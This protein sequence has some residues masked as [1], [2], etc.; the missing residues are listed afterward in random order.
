MAK[1]LK[2]KRLWWIGGILVVATAV[3]FIVFSLRAQANT[4]TQVNEAEVVEAFIGDL[5]ASATASGRVLPRRSAALAPQTPGRVT[6]V[7][8]RPGD[9]VAAGDPLLQLDTADL[10]LN[11]ATAEQTLRLQQ[12][13]LD[14]LVAAP[15]AAELAAAEAAVTSA[16]ANLD[17]IRSG[18][19]AEEIAA[20]EADLRAAEAAVSSSAAQLEQARGSVTAADIASAEAALA[21]AEANLKSVEIQYTRNPDP[22]NIQANTALAEARQDV[23]SAQA[24]L[25]NLRA[26]PQESQV[27]GAQAGLAAAQ[28]Q[29][30]ATAAQLNQLTADPTGAE[31]AGAEAQLVQAQATLADLQEGAT[32][33]EIAAAEAEVAQA[34][35]SLEDAQAVLDAATLRAPFAGVVTAVS[36]HEGE[37]ASGAVVELMDDASLE[38]VL[39]VDEVDIGQIEVGQPATVT[40]ETWPE[41]EI[42]GTVTAVSPA[43]TTPGS[44]LISYEVRVSLGEVALPV[45][46]GMTANASLVTAEKQNVLLVPNR[47]INA[48]RSAGTYSVNVQEGDTVREVPVTIGLRDDTYT[49]IRSG[50]SAGDRIVVGND[51]PR[52]R[53]SPGPPDNE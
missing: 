50:L 30:D 31:I 47:A 40:L 44:G 51:L 12:A 25:D 28:A 9:S 5:A 13:N 34:Q 46:A 49:E 15:S 48:D 20:S 7:F 1:R 52:V 32:P 45:R 18:A 6:D 36:V 53:F 16:Q 43:P 27:G 10:E 24:R 39:E 21:A 35:L 2:D 29:R 22:D 19:S 4:T 3:I 23:A 42:E 14:A 17:E 33:E 26:G 8:V 37:F 38:V 41:T 11:V